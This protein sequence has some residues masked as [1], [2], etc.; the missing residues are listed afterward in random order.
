MPSR[1]FQPLVEVFLLVEQ[2]RQR[3]SHWTQA[4]A[5]LD[6]STAPPVASVDAYYDPACNQAIF[7]LRY[8]ELALGPT[9]LG[10]IVEVA[11]LA[12]IGMIQP[13]ELSDGDRKRFV[14]E[15]LS[16][17]TLHVGDQRKVVGALVELVRR[18]RS[19]KG[20]TTPPSTE[21]VSPLLPRSS[22]VPGRPQ[23]DPGNP[24]LVAR[25]TRKLGTE[26]GEEQPKS[27]RDLPVGG[28]RTSKPF[29]VPPMPEGEP[30]PDAKRVVNEPVAASERL[31]ANAL[32]RRD[33]TLRPSP[34][35]IVRG[36]VH[37]ADTVMMPTAQAQQ[38]LEAASREIEVTTEQYM[39][40]TVDPAQP[41]VIYGRYLRGGRWIPTRIGALSLKG[42]SLMA[43][44]LPRV[45]DR[46]DVSLSFEKHRALVR[47]AVAKVS[48]MQEAQAT[49]ATTFSVNFELDDASRRELTALLTAARAAKVTIKPPPAR[50][51]RRYPVEWPMTFGTMRGAVRAEALDVS[52]EGMFVR[53]LNDLALDANLTFT[54][55]LDDGGPP[56]SGRA[57][58]VR[59]VGEVEARGAGLSPGYGLMILEMTDAERERWGGFLARIEKRASKRV[60]IGAAPA[61]L[62]ELQSGL[63]AAGYAV[64]GGS[65]RDIIA[66]LASAEARPVDA[67]LIDAAWLVGGSAP[68]WVDSLF[69]SRNVPYVA[70]HGDAKR[71]RVAIDKLLSVV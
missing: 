40:K 21:A 1:V 45:D 31:L 5:P 6:G 61:R 48:S 39:P 65:D 71:A 3:L 43:G 44:A 58:A 33:H 52:T 38:M 15:R 54:A 67:A 59:R 8:D 42:A 29:T 27:T 30:D 68:A 11:L 24:V 20:M 51:T 62:A 2:P 35:V 64:T 25:G 17:C 7:G 41:G 55:V 50:S 47:G 69:A 23:T 4:L 13:A 37:R 60:L 32:P 63:V 56:V 36:G 26:D 34:N 46:V 14:G 12:E 28:A 22:S 18:I 16:S 57:R 19:Q 49:G 9:R 10:F 53:P 70:M 66:Q